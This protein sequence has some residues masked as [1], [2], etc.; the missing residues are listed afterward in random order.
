M[1]QKITI[2]SILVFFLLIILVCLPFIPG[3]SSLGFSPDFLGGMLYLWLVYRPHL[4]RLPGVA[5]LGIIQDGLYG[6]PLGISSIEMMLLLLFVQFLKHFLLHLSF[7][8]VFTGYALSLFIHSALEWIILS[9]FIHEWVSLIPLLKKI[10][11]SLLTY[12]FIC[13]VGLRLQYAIDEYI[14]N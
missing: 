8:F 5:I 1:T 14:K 12:P 3:W 4:I 6:Y 13:E 11:F 7:W 9:C 2:S 10:G